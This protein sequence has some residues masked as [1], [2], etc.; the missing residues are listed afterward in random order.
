M[1]TPGTRMAGANSTNAAAVGFLS[2]NSDGR[3]TKQDSQ[4]LFTGGPDDR[5]H[6]TVD[7]AVR[8]DGVT[9]AYPHVDAPDFSELPRWEPLRI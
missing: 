6:L 9:V 5:I 2:M 8:P 7:H 4:V 1:T 3:W